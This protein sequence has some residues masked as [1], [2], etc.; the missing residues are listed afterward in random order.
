MCDT[1]E[2]VTD[3]MRRAFSDM[4]RKVKSLERY[5]TILSHVVAALDNRMGF[6]AE[7]WEAVA[8]EV[9]MN[10]EYSF[11]DV[12]QTLIGCCDVDPA[13]FNK[14]FTVSVTMPL[15]F[16]VQIDAP[17]E[18]TASDMVYDNLNNMWP[19]DIINSYDVDIDTS[20]IEITHIEEG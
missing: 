8:C 19:L 1:P 9:Q 6:N 18:D 15:Y 13:M 3:N 4:E 20:S 2:V 5:E 11:D 7:T 12:V 14:P 16:A 10:T 17:D